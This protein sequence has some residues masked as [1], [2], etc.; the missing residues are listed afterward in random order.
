VNTRVFTP[1]LCLALLLTLCFVAPVQ[2]AGMAPDEGVVGA[3][4]TI[5]GLS[6][7]SYSIK[8]DGVGVKQGTLPGGGSVTFTVPDTAGGDHT[9]TVDNPTGTQVLSATFSVL[10]SISIST[11]SGVVGDEVT[12]SGK[13]FAAS[14]SSIK[15][16]YDGTD[17]KTGI[18]A[19]STGTWETTFS[20][21]I[22]A[23]GSHT[24]DASG[25]ITQASDVPD[26]TVTINPEISMTPQSGNVGTSISVTGMGFGKSEGSIVVKFDSTNIKSGISA[27]TKGSW[28]TSFA[29]PNS[30]KGGHTIDASGAATNADDVPD[31]TFIVS[32]AVAVKPA[33][34]V[35]GDAVTI[36]GCGFG[37]NESGI[38]ITLDGNVV[39]SDITANNEGCWDSS[40]TIPEIVGGDHIIDAYGVSTTASE[41]A[42]TKITVLSKMI[43]DPAEGNVGGTIAIKGTGF[44]AGKELILKYDS[45]ELATKFSTDDKGNFQASLVVPKS[46]GGN[47]NIGA[48]D[49]SGATAT[50]IFVMESTPPSVP[51]IISPKEGSRVGL[52]D[53]IRPT[54]KWSAVNDP[55]GVSYD[56]QI[57]SQSDFAT[58]LLSKDN[59]AESEYTLTDE[60]ALSRARYYWRVKAVDGASNDSG[61]TQSIEFKVGL[62]PLWVFII[63]VVIGV[64]F[65]VRMYFFV[66]KMRKE[67]R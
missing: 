40:M 7:G 48:T 15:V 30:T 8:W 64:A 38:S 20:L 57:S 66:R 14:E 65:L 50:A 31:L 49:T 19:G 2:A 55:S 4:V 33:S 13:G 39:K 45:T 17:T 11:D 3:T 35:T 6:S 10:P 44:G 32:S 23:Q 25:Q 16:T 63:I 47:H 54:F 43:L 1:V 27:D 29:V 36:T 58:T 46:Q 37:G 42:D 18:S 28:N 60:E 61:W 24:V 21:P 62:M 67:R 59:L 22:S 26:V 51:Q 56:L 12:V 41:V 53:N 5:S 34:G 52:F 9:V